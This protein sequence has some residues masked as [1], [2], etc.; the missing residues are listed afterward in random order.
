MAL[1]ALHKAN[2]VLLLQGNQSLL[3]VLCRSPTATGRDPACG[4]LNLSAVAHYS[5]S[6][7]DAGAY[8]QPGSKSCGA[9]F[10]HCSCCFLGSLW[11]T[12]LLT[13]MSLQYAMNCAHVSRCA[14]TAM[15]VWTLNRT[16]DGFVS[17]SVSCRVFLASTLSCNV[18]T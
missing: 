12:F 18:A 6:Q 3:R 17:M 15:N 14:R 9:G 7:A 13:N 5:A 4:E 11:E 8:V 10:L 2:R 1:V 16:I